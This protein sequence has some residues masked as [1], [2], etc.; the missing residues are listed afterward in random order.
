MKLIHRTGIVLAILAIAGF[1]LNAQ[2]V[3]KPEKG[4]FLLDNATL[5]PVSSDT[6]VGDLLVRDGKIAAI[7]EQLEPPSDAQIVD[8]NGKYVYPGMI[9]AG[10][11]LGL[12]E[13][14]SISLTNDANELGE[15]A[16]HMQALTAV[17]PNSVLIPVT[18]VNGITTVLT[19]PAGG[20]FPGQAALVHLVGYTPAQMDAGFEPLVINFPRTGRRGRFDQ[21]TDEKIKEDDKKALEN[22]DEVWEKANSYARVDSA[23]KAGD[24]D[25]QPEL[26][27]M[28]PAV[29]GEVSVLINVDREKEILAA[30][31]WVTKHKI[32]AIFCGVDEGWRVADS[33]AAAGIPVITGP[34]LAMPD[35][36]YDRYDT[37]YRNAGLMAKAGVKVALQTEEKENVRN[38]PYHAGF[39]AAY[40]MGRE[41]ALRAVTLT[42]A[43]IFGVDDQVGS[44]EVGKLAN[45]VVANG[46]LFETSTDIEDV[47]ILGYRIPMESRHSLLYDEFLKREPGL[48]VQPGG[49]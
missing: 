10:T 39:A 11:Q 30:I 1:Q 26:R 13:I 12:A 35:R 3:G 32:N 43:E 6:L 17:N 34:V 16:P 24:L 20:V 28:L 8:C 45:L 47:F 41:E 22:L 27:A 25:Y 49:E 19:K 9:D 18:R 46:D 44:L 48:Q 23:G 37:P 4:T 2:M 38:L 36:S 31:H 40:G 5:I 15:F 42:P 7:G 29:R 21:R 33:I 14:G